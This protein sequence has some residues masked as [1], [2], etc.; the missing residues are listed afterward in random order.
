MVN[1][2]HQKSYNRKNQQTVPEI[3]LI[4]LGRAIWW[5]LTLPFRRGDKRTSG[6]S[7]A[8]KQYIAEKRQE[9]EQMMMSDNA[10]ELKHAVIEADKLVDHI[11]KAKGYQGA[12]FAD[13][14]RSAESYMDSAMYQRLW[15]AHKVRNQIA[16]QD[17][18]YSK[19]EII[20]AAK[21]LLSYSQL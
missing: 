4:S 5:L 14:L 7:E 11:L 21:Q 1:Y 2:Q 3:I 19:D 20:R 17:S 15:E 12:T 6:I 9:I 16:H 8:D 10:Y 18:H 13:R